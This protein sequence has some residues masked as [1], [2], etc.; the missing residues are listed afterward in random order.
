VFKRVLDISFEE[1]VLIWNSI[2]NKIPIEKSPFEESFLNLNFLKIGGGAVLLLWANTFSPFGMN[3][4]KRI[5]EWNISHFYFLSPFVKQYM[6]EDYTKLERWRNT[7]KEWIILMEL[8]GSDV[9][10]EYS[11]SLSI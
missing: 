3:R 8:S 10:A 4:Q 9:F 1:V 7:G 6:S 2:K 5:L 11:I